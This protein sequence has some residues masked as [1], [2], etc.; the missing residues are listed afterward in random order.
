LGQNRYRHDDDAFK[1]TIIWIKEKYN[2]IILEKTIP[3]H[4]IVFTTGIYEK[5]KQMEVKIRE[6]GIDAT[7]KYYTYLNISCY[8]LN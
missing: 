2:N 5:F 7:C 4:A 3:V 6:C 1:S 8:L